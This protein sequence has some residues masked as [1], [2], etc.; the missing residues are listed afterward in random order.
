MKLRASIMNTPLLLALM[1]TPVAVQA[2]GDVAAGRAKAKACASCHGMDG[3]GRVSLAGKKADYLE[4]QLHAFKNGRRKQE[5]MNRMTQ[6][7]N[8]QDLADLAAYYA[9]L[10]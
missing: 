9:S 3:K 10:K 8:D 6:V 4:A 7:L 2:A 5:M 1:L